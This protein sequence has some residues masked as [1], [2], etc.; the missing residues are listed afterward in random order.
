MSARLGG[1]SGLLSLG[2]LAAS[3]KW[4]HHWGVRA[5]TLVVAWGV[6]VVGALWFSGRSVRASHRALEKTPRLARLGFWLAGVSLV[7]LVVAGIAA[8]A[9][10]DPAGACGGG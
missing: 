5:D 9:V 4:A 7:A 2:L 1:I 10:M 6:A 8:A 3:I